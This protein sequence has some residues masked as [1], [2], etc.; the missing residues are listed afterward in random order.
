MGRVSHWIRMLRFLLRSDEPLGHGSRRQTR[1][2]SGL[3]SRHRPMVLS[4]VWHS[5]C[6]CCVPLPQVTEH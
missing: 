4:L 2:V 3:L 5:A 1:M 6:L